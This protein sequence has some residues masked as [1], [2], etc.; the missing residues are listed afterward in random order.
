MPGP[1]STS[2]SSGAARVGRLCSPRSATRLTANWSTVGITTSR[3]WPNRWPPSSGVRRGRPDGH[4]GA[5][6]GQEAAAKK[7]P[8]KKSTAKK[9]GQEGSGQEGRG[10]EGP[11]KA[12]AKKSPAKKAAGHE[13]P[14][15]KAPARKAPKPTAARGQLR[16]GRLTRPPRRRLDR[17][18]VDR[19][20]AESRPGPSTYRATVPSVSGAIADNRRA[21]RWPGR[22]DRAARAPPRFVSRV[23]TSS[24]PWPASPSTRPDRGPSTPALRP[25]GSPIA[26]YRAGPPRCSRSTSAAASSTTGSG[27]IPGRGQPASGST[28]ATSPSATVGGRPVD[29]VVADLSFI[30]LTPG[31]ARTDR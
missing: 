27:P 17:A 12:A 2:S 6:G 15:K 4:R 26:C 11:A 16:D 18:L 21:G 24:P 20:L 19:G 23:A 7:T 13:G 9:P 30:S 31:G 8:A 28:S 14:A 29:L 3:T 5:D 10:Q 22:A 25:G 1:R